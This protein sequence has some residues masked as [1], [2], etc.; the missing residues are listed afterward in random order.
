M[1][2]R[3]IHANSLTEVKSALEKM[4]L[5]DP[6][7]KPGLAFVFTSL[8]QEWQQLRSLLNGHN[9]AIFGATTAGEFTEKGMSD[10]GFTLLLFDMDPSYFQ[11]IIKE[12]DQKFFTLSSMQDDDKWE[13]NFSDPAFIILS[14]MGAFPADEIIKTILNR[15]GAVANIIGGLVGDMEVFKGT[16]FSNEHSSDNGLLLLLIDQEKVDVKGIAVSGW[17]PMGTEK[18]VTSSEGNWVSTIDGMPAMDVVEKYLGFNTLYEEAPGNI[19]KLNTIYPLQVKREGGSP[20]MIPTLFFNKESRAVMV[21]QPL[22][23]GT[24]FRFSMPPDLDVIDTVIQSSKNLKEDQLPEADALVVFSCA[25]RY[26]SLGPMMSEELDGLA[27]TW[28]KPMAGFFSLGEFGS[29]AGGKPEFH[30]TT[31]SWVALKEK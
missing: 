17:K 28:Q 29:V 14:T 23:E 24:L 15:Y 26:E 11:I 27:G 1:K 31:C 13:T 6:E 21:G 2:A 18:K 30:G 7:F 19:I 20:A 4:M 8:K 5:D 9:V 25:G 22:S 16:V 3:S 12:Y 10:S